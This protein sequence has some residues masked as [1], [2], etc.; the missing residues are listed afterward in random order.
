MNA[1]GRKMKHRPQDR[2]KI[3]GWNIH[4]KLGNPAQR[5][6]LGQDMREMKLDIC[7]LSETRWQIDADVALP[8]GGGRI[9]NYRSHTENAHAAYGMG[10]WM[11]TAWAERYEKDGE[12]EKTGDNILETARRTQ[13]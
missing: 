13:R 3:A 2:T 7:V 5:E 1:H 4:G 9:I 6:A 8:E 12:L 11:N 10:I